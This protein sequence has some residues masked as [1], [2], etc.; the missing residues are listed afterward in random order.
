MPLSKLEIANMVNTIE[1]ITWTFDEI[2]SRFSKLTIYKNTTS[3]FPEPANYIFIKIMEDDNFVYYLSTYSNI[4]SSYNNGSYFYKVDKHTAI[5][6]YNFSVE[7]STNITDTYGMGKLLELQMP[8]QKCYNF[9]Y[10]FRYL[11]PTQIENEEQFN[12]YFAVFNTTP[13]QS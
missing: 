1:S 4:N 10:K 3:L 8:T 13:V 5:D 7:S 12:Q 6:V 2:K 9:I 11:R